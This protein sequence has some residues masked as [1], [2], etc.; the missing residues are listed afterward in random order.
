MA[1][2]KASDRTARARAEAAAGRFKQVNGD[3]LRVAVHAPN[4][5]AGHGR[6]NHVRTA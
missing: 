2:Q 6:P 1:R 4:R 3:G 5:M